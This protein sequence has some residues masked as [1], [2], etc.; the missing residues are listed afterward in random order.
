M[1]E[2]KFYLDMTCVATAELEDKWYDEAE[3]DANDEHCQRPATGYIVWKTPEDLEAAMDYIGSFFPL[4]VPWRVSI[5]P[6]ESICSWIR[7]EQLGLA[8]R[9]QPIDD[10]FYDYR[11]Y[12]DTEH[13]YL[14]MPPDDLSDERGQFWNM[15]VNRDGELPDDWMQIDNEGRVILNGDP[16]PV[17][18]ANMFSG[19][20]LKRDGCIL[21]TDVVDAVKQKRAAQL[22][23]M[24]LA[25]KR[26]HNEP[27]PNGKQ[28]TALGRATINWLYTSDVF[29]V[30]ADFM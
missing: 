20:D 18:M 23:A 27:W 1:F 30:V 5:D 3:G 2:F 17:R 13:L 26:P 7:Y 10:I 6:K 11:D 22:H 9:L 29:S 19:E 24:L 25:T 16:R 21:F 12:H 4:L 28:A 8:P 14:E 15:C